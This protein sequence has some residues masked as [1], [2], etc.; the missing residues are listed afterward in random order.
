MR[1]FFV[2]LVL[3]AVGC[4]KS[5]VLVPDNEWKTVPDAERAQLDREHA[6]EVAKADAERTA[7]RVALTNARAAATPKPMQ[8]G[9]APAASGDEWATAMAQYEQNRRAAI[10]SVNA[11]TAEWQRARIAFYE[12]RVELADANVE[13]LQSA[14]EVTRAKAV[15]R[16]R[17]G[18]DTYDAAE[19]RGQLANTQERWYAAETRATAAREA[20]AS[21]TAKL[22]AAKDTYASIVRG[23]PNAPRSDDKSMQ[24]AS[25]KDQP[26]RARTS[27]RERTS[28]KSG[29]YLTLGG[30]VARK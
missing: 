18:F 21:A 6:A 15:D 5:Y 2:L 19:F 11:A 3:T 10:T 30:R 23:G 13:V 4:A 24:L 22:A 12:R 20:L 7:A 26:L 16:H 8:V 9:P 27:W 29:R 17:L 28:A 25:W 14:Y 1:A